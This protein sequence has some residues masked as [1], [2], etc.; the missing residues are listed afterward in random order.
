MSPG[1]ERIRFSDE[2]FLRRH[3]C[4]KHIT[5]KLSLRGMGYVP[6]EMLEKNEKTSMV[7]GNFNQHD[8]EK[9]MVGR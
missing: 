2:S 7:L 5:H 4:E 6:R 9:S 3:V 1:L 8:P